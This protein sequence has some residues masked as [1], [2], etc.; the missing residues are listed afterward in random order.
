MWA[1][2]GLLHALLVHDH[3][4]MPGGSERHIKVFSEIGED[5]TEPF[6]AVACLSCSLL[7]I[8]RF[9]AYLLFYE[10]KNV[11]APVILETTTALPRKDIPETPVAIE[12]VHL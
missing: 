10:I 4:G 8:Q 2:L 5:G 6:F 11:F 1:S 9:A 12:L 3:G 7:L